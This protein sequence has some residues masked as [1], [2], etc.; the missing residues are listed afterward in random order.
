MVVTYQRNSNTKHGRP[1]EANEEGCIPNPEHLA[2]RIGKDDVLLNS[3]GYQ[4]RGRVALVDIR[5]VEKDAPD[6]PACVGQEEEVPDAIQFPRC[7][8]RLLENH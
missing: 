5:V 8:S 4:G 2:D 3:I 7:V 6:V 1:Q